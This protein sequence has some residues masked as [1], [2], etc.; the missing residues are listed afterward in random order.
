MRVSLDKITGHSGIHVAGASRPKVFTGVPSDPNFRSLF[1]G[2]ESH[3]LRLPYLGYALNFYSVLHANTF[4]IYIH[5]HAYILSTSYMAPSSPRRRTL[6]IVL[7]RSGR[8]ILSKVADG[9]SPNEIYVSHLYALR[10]ASSFAYAHDRFT[11][12]LRVTF[13]T[14]GS[15]SRRV[16]FMPAPNLKTKFELNCRHPRNPI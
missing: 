13:N 10:D 8:A 11:S 1:F 16:P 5:I 12:S 6:F 4:R 2:L 15:T 3:N 14:V 7:P 9:K